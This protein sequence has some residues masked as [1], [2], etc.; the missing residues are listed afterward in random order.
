MNRT[1]LISV[2][3]KTGICDF[4]SILQKKYF[5]SL[6]STGKTAELLANSGLNVKKVSEVTG[7]PEMLG[8]RVKTLHPAIFGGILADLNNKQ[9]YS[10]LKINNINPISIVV[11]NLYPFEETI[12]NGCTLNEAIEQIDIGGVSLLRAA[13]KNFMN[14]LVI[15]SPNDYTSIIEELEKNNGEVPLNLK[16]RLAIKAF[17]T[18]SHYDSIISNY[19]SSG[20]TFGEILNLSFS[21]KMSLRYGE[22]PHQKAAFYISSNKDPL[23]I[24]SFLQKQGKDLSFNNILDIDST[25]SAIITLGFKLPVSVVIKHTNPCGAAVAST[26]NKAFEKAWSGDSLAAFGGIVGV[27]RKV[28]KK[29]ARLMLSKGFFEVLV[30]PEIETE[31]LE[32]F[33]QKK[34]LRVLVNPEFSKQVISSELDFKHIRGGALLQE[35][36]NYELS[37]SDLHVVTEKKPTKVQIKN[38]MFAWKICKVSKSNTIVLAKNNFLV[39]SGVGQQDRKRCCELAI[40]KAGTRAKGSVCASDAFF[41]FSDGPELLIKAG[42]KSII[43]PGGSIRDQD[44]IDLCNKHGVSMVFTG[45]RCFKH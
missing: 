29:L 3:D 45:Y 24:S 27:N 4:A 38:L 18:T 5:Y 19:F 40:S 22:N 21:R 42:I 12:K 34:N 9:H 20:D 16:K 13:A 14:V 26:I 43:Q 39:S 32:L 11:V 44:T 2:Y 25:I 41:P 6:I 37:N 30:C 31:A 35:Q 8:G 36:D 1:A 10:D 17:S 15:S 33:S 23:S 7:F 28:D